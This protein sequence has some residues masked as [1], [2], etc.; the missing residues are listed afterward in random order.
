MFYTQ[1]ACN[2]RTSA[3]I[4][5]YIEQVYFILQKI[6]LSFFYYIFYILTIA[7]INNNNFPG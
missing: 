6:R 4:I 1:I 2:S 7:I 5:S 3:F